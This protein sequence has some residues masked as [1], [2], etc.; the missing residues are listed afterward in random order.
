MDSHRDDYQ[1]A[2]V[3][4][5]GEDLIDSSPSFTDQLVQR[6]VEGGAAEIVTYLVPAE[7]FEQL[8]TSARAAQF[9]SFRAATEAEIA[10]L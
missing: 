3:R 2:L 10:A 4:L 8:T 7:F 6:V 9:P 1:G 5:F